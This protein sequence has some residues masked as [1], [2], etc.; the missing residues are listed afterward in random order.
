MSATHAMHG[1]WAH[2]RCGPFGRR[3]AWLAMAGGGHEPGGPGGFGYRGPPFGR[4]F[5]PRGHGGPKARRGDVRAAMLVLLEEEP[6]NGYQLMQEIERRSDGIWRPSA[7]SVY[8]AL[9]LLEDEGLV[10]SEERDGRK[11]FALTDAGREHVA[12]HR[13]DLAAPW[14][15]M[16]A[17]MPEGVK[18]LRELIGQVAGAA[19]QAHQAGDAAQGERVREVLVEARR[20]IYRILADE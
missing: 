9:A 15:A 4:G 12:E 10:R 16:T 8:P 13:D 11:V 3:A 20:A 7:G 2:G 14:E 6:R 5:G 19:V 1:G 18:G 17:A